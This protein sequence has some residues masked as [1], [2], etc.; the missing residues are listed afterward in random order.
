MTFVITCLCQRTDGTLGYIHVLYCN[1]IHLGSTPI[2]CTQCNGHSQVFISVCKIHESGRVGKAFIT[3][4]W[5]Q[6]DARWMWGEGEE[7][8][9]KKKKKHTL[10]LIQALYCSSGLQ[11]LV[12]SQLLVLTSR[13]IAFKLS[14]Y[15]FEY[16]P[17]PQIGRSWYWA[18]T[19]ATSDKH[20]RGLGMRLTSCCIPWLAFH[21]R[22]T[23]CISRGAAHPLPW[24]VREGAACKPCST[25]SQMAHHTHE[26]CHGA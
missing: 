24:G 22:L 23:F 9:H 13:K 1:N 17:L 14:S 16:R 25:G 18:K 21:Y 2:L 7:P 8:N 10:P 26:N 3:C 5:H 6:V 11:T 12:W 19:S 15:I 4:E 20:C